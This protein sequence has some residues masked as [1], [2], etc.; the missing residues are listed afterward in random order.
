MCPGVLSVLGF[1][2]LPIPLSHT[3]LL[4]VLDHTKPAPV[5]RGHICSLHLEHNLKYSIPVPSL[6]SSNSCLSVE[7]SAPGQ[8]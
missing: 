8:H 1:H 2:S 6:A 5:P 4:E 7:K 3:G